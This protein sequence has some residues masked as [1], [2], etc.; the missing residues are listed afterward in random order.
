[1]GIA[2]PFLSTACRSITNWL[3]PRLLGPKALDG[4]FPLST[5]QTYTHHFQPT[6]VGMDF[7]NSVFIDNKANSTVF[8]L[9]NDDTGQQIAVAPFCQADMDVIGLPTNSCTFTGSSVGGVDVPIKYRS[10]RGANIQYSAT[11][12]GTPSGTVQ[13]NGTVVTTPFGENF[14]QAPTQTITS[15]LTWQILF[16]ALATRKDLVI[17]NPATQ[18]TQGGIAAPES[19]YINFGGP[20]AGA[21]NFAGGGIYEITPGG[22]LPPYL[23]KDTRAVNIAAGSAGHAFFAAQAI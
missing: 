21:P 20:S 2:V 8:V 17:M 6:E 19:L 7:V 3:Q 12:P 1:M 9:T 15:V 22:N 4:I 10:T 11:S 5:M 16:P 13:I 18:I 23:V 14:S